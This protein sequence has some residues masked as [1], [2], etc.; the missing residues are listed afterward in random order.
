MSAYTERG[1]VVLDQPQHAANS[2]RLRAA[3]ALRLVFDTAAL[4]F[5]ERFRA[6]K[7][8][9]LL[10]ALAGAKGSGLQRLLRKKEVDAAVVVSHIQQV[11]EVLFRG[12]LDTAVT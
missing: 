8:R 9:P 2:G 6:N 11:V 1:C 3:Y 5:T 4:R 12:F 7:K 10:R